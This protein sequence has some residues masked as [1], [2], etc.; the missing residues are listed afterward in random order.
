MFSKQEEEEKKYG[1]LHVTKF[2]QVVDKLIYTD[3]IGLT[4]LQCVF[5]KQE[6]EEEKEDCLLHMTE[7]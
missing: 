2:D 5:P 7:V 1:L 3:C 4:F 6:E